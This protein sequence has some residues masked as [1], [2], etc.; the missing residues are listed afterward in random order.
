[1]LPVVAIRALAAERAVRWFP[2]LAGARHEVDVRL[3]ATR[4]RCTLYD[5]RLTGPAAARRVVVKY[6][7][8]LPSSPA[9]DR[10]TLVPGR[11]PPMQQAAL[12]YAGLRHVEAGLDPTDRRFGAVRALDLLGDCPVLVLEHVNAPTLRQVLL[13]RSRLG[14]GDRRLRRTDSAAHR[15]AGA[16]LAHF[17]RTAGPLATDERV[18]GRDELLEHV[19]AFGDYLV[20]A[21]TTGVKDIV[22][23]SAATVAALLPARLP[24][25]V[26]HGDFAPRNVFVDP[27]GRV[28]VFDPM[29]RWRAPLL[30]DVCRYLV[31]VRL[32]GLQVHSHGTAFSSGALD[33]VEDDFLAGYFGG[34]VPTEQVTAF[35]LVVLLDKW[36]ALMS[37]GPRSGPRAIAAG[38]RQRW[39]TG[40]VRREAVRLL[41]QAESA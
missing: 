31:G 14:V 12:E 21:G 20:D 32:L 19:A 41:R 37:A 28:S 2:E 22:R 33:Q 36:S 18:G 13:S 8:D 6:R 4:P 24:L 7:T 40:Y 25:M 34:A 5:V 9:T 39:V 11:V 1:M 38:A 26:S 17:H 27:D 3:L 16:W 23:R 30:E 10:P 15:N 29:P 35:R